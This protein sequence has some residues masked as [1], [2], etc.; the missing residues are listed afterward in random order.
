MKIVILFISFL[1]SIVEPLTT[2]EQ[3]L[4]NEHNI[5]IDS[6]LTHIFVFRT[7][8]C[9]NGF[10][11]SDAT[12]FIDKN[13]TTNTAKKIFIL[14][15]DLDTVLIKKIDKLQNSKLIIDHKQL[16]Y[17]GF[18]IYNS[19]YIS[20]NKSQENIVVF[21]KKNMKEIKKIISNK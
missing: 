5:T 9:G 14:D 7:R 19:Y 16:E 12:N 20:I 8:F 15:C 10:C 11:S 2:I 17:Y 18:G 3:Y 4:N 13:L 6:S 21:K 1:F